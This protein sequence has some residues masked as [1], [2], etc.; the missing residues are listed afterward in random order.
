[1]DWKLS[2][3]IDM[4][5]FAFLHA[6]NTRLAS[7]KPELSSDNFRETKQSSAV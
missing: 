4:E 3:V 5:D 6:A 7:S 2:F 1:M